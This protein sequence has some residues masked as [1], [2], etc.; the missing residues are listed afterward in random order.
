[1]AADGK[2]GGLHRTLACRRARRRPA[3]ARRRIVAVAF[4][5]T[6]PLGLGA[7]C[8]SDDTSSNAGTTVAL[9]DCPFS[10]TAAATQGGQQ[11]A[12]AVLSSVTN[13]KSGC[14]DSLAF[15][16]ATPPPAWTVAYSTGPF[17]DAATNTTVSVPG[18]STLV[19]TFAATTYANHS[20][21][22]TA[23]TSN[24]DYVT[25]IN[26]ITGPNGSLQWILSL[27]AP[28]QYQTSSSEVPSNF[29]LAVG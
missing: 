22:T 17:V 21:P 25:A 8:G 13:S 11:A 2:P 9:A 28:A 6:L 12:K 26:V 29:T 20:T 5:L 7:A 16:F 15:A 4:A 3:E 23:P 27:A 24:L 10:G 18:P 14:I 1:M 19:V